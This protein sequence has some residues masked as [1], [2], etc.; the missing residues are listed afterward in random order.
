M[1]MLRLSPILPS[2]IL[3][4]TLGTFPIRTRDFYASYM[5]SALFYAPPTA[6]VGTLFSALTDVSGED[7]PTSDFTSPLGLSM[8]ILGV[9]ATV[10]VTVAITVFTK[11]K[12]RGII[13]IEEHKAKEGKGEEGVELNAI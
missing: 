8:M 6:Y 13:D 2:A 9:L 11:R 1:I 3:N 7:N 5:V 4:Y 10:G 12:L